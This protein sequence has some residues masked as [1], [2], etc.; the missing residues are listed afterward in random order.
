MGVVPDHSG[1]ERFLPVPSIRKLEHPSVIL[2]DSNSG[3]FKYVD[4]SSNIDARE[5]E[6]SKGRGRVVGEEVKQ[7]GYCLI[8][9]NLAQVLVP[10]FVTVWLLDWC[11]AGG[12]AEGPVPRTQEQMES[13]TLPPH[14]TD[15]TLAETHGRG[16][17]RR[18]RRPCPA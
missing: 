8:S 14:Q 18:R 13:R 5:S 2:H 7:K 1:A 9:N 3:Q 17:G 6:G 15:R 4:V 16:R 10:F 11:A 12:C